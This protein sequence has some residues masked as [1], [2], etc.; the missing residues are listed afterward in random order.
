MNSHPPDEMSHRER[1][2]AERHHRDQYPAQAGTT[3]HSNAG[4]LTIHQPVASRLPGAIHSPGGLLANH[5]SAP[6][7][8]LGGSNSFG[9][10]AESN[11]PHA[12]NAQ[13]ASSQMFGAIGG[14]NVGPAASAAPAA[15]SLFGGPLQQE[16]TRASQSG[17]FGGAAGGGAVGGVA[18][19][20][21]PGAGNG[22]SHPMNNGPGALPQ[23]QQP[24]L[25]VSPD[26]G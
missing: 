21:A 19:A 10:N 9:G 8:P 6:S 1:E 16:G 18:A 7:I 5:G 25:N 22:G 23:G 13:S 2:S 12:H 4:S 11:R 14:P 24:I 3:H 20:A 26:L 15:S 17:A